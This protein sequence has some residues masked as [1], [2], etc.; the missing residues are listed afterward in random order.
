MLNLIKY[1][2][3][4]K[5]RLISIVLITALALNLLIMTRGPEGSVLFLTLSPFHLY[6]LYFV[7]I[8]KMYS[9]DLNKKTGYMLFMTPSS[10]YRIISSKLI[11]AVIEG[12][13]LL[14]IYFLFFA[15]NG[16]YILVS[17][18]ETVDFSSIISNINKIFSG[19]LGYGF[20]IFHLFM[21]LQ[22]ILILII[23]FIT[24]IYTAITI[25]KSL[26]SEA[27]FG[28]LFSF[29]IFLLINWIVSTL[30]NG[31]YNFLSKVS[32]Y[33]NSLDNIAGAGRFTPETLMMIFIP[34]IG[35][36]II[37]ATALSWISGYLLEKK[38]NL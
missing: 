4:R 31:F 36:S 24:T 21:L 1:E 27:K 6:I 14:L 3:I 26:F 32:P 5:Y 22:T 13:G 7:D 10:G 2:F 17:L 18:D 23:A 38:I 11:A 15:L 28:G 20:N 29:I 37:Q 35:F 19:S 12:F 25:R 9:D 33:Y 8:I 30:S 16:V 34:I